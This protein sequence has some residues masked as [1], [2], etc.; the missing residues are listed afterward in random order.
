MDIQFC[1]KLYNE[2]MSKRKLASIRKRI[3]KKSPKLNLFLVTLPLGEDGV[4]EIYWYPELLQ[5][6]YQELERDLYVVG[7]ANDREDAFELIR[8]IV[9]DAGITNGTIS[10]K[11]FFKE[12]SWC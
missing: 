6:A 10:I 5:K 2:N 12:N 9:E 4:L 8:T 1:E 11:E 3:R 7:V